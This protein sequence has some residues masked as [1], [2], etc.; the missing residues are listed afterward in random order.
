MEEYEGEINNLRKKY[1]EKGLDLHTLKWSYKEYFK[2]YM[3]LVR[4]KKQDIPKKDDHPDI[5]K[6]IESVRQLSENKNYYDIL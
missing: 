3:Y 6:R 4:N 2:A 1:D 5:L